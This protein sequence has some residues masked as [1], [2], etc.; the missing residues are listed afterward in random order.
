V[1]VA[2]IYEALTGARSYQD[3][4]APERA[5]LVLARLAGDK[6]NTAL[7]KAFVNAITFFPLG[8]L[9]RTN[10]GDVGVVVR[11]NAGEPLHPVVALLDERLENPRGQ[12]D[13]AAR[14]TSGAYEQH[15]LETLRPPNDFDVARFLTA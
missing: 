14:N 1:S 13:T 2:D 3:P 7:V 9:V 5:C 6:L 12:L 4:T 15:I 8:S 11:L 10:R